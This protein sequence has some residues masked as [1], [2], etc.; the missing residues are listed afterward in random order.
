MISTLGL[1]LFFA[2]VAVTSKRVRS[3]K[4]STPAIIGTFA[5]LV[6]IGVY[7]LGCVNSDFTCTGDGMGGPMMA[8]ALSLFVP[9]AAIVLFCFVLIVCKSIRSLC[10]FK[11]NNRLLLFIYAWTVIALVTVFGL[12]SIAN[13]IIIR[14]FHR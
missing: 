8:Y 13:R 10:T 2:G 12:E 9:N 11:R 7:F 5:N 1:T 3:I 14:L 4:I 6:P